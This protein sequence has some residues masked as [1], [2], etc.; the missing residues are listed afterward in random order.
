MGGPRDPGADDDDDNDGD[1]DKPPRF[2]GG[3]TFVSFGPGGMFASKEQSMQF[4]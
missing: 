2:E 4:P 1:G 3:G